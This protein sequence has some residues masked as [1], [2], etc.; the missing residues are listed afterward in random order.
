MEAE[1]SVSE[2]NSSSDI[3]VYGV[4]WEVESWYLF[5]LWPFNFSQQLSKCMP[6]LD[7]GFLS[8]IDIEKQE[9]SF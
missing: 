8:V 6:I 3:S 2:I 1:N 5:A 4:K 7:F 9:S